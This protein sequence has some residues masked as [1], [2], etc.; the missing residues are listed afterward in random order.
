MSKR[1]ALR[2]IAYDNW[3]ADIL[4]M[5]PEEKALL[6]DFHILMDTHFMS[7]FT[8]QNIYI[9]NFFSVPQNM[10]LRVKKYEK[11]SILE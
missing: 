7:D 3:F 2:F 4:L 1:K 11:N 6:S 5:A 10:F 8:I 9:Y